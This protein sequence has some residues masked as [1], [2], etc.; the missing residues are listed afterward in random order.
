[1]SAFERSENQS[2]GKA[3]IAQA[4]AAIEIEGLTFCYEGAREAVLEGVSFSVGRGEFVGL[5]GPN[6]GGKTTLLKLI[7]KLL[8]LQQGQIRLFGQPINEFQDWARVGYVR[9]RLWE[10][11]RHFPATVSEIVSNGRLF[12]SGFIRPLRRADRQAV[13]AAL[14]QV[15]LRAL[16]SKAIGELSAGQQ[17]RAF[18]A[19]A[20]AQEPELLLLDEP[21]AAVDPKAEADFYGLLGQLNHERGLT[22]VLVSHDVETVAAQ[23]IKIV[24][25]N[26]R[27]LFCGPPQACLDSGVLE[28]VFTEPGKRPLRHGHPWTAKQSLEG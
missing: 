15:G 19:R 22:L 16:A 21:T 2:V 20:L 13:A 24:C 8:P 12:R 11:D 5:L 23:A 26:R 14:E 18:L 10:F 27:L 9:Q 28:Q 1:M 4:S 25:L 3:D 7:L 17:Q 6:G